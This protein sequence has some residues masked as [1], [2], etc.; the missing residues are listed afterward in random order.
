MDFMF[1]FKSLSISL[2]VVIC[3]NW[4]LDGS[5]QTFQGTEAWCAGTL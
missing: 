3:N 1:Y 5:Q 2:K 4:P